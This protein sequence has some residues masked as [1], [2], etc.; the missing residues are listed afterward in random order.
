MA[1]RQGN[2]VKR[3]Y[4]LLKPEEEDALH[5]SR[6]LP[7]EQRPF[8]RL[9]KRLLSPDSLL[10]KR[11]TLKQLPSPPAEAGIDDSV[12]S[13]SSSTDEQYS[14]FREDMLL[15]FVLFDSTMVRIQLLRNS[16]EKERARYATE[17]S[18]IM[19]TSDSVRLNITQ[20]RQELEEEQ[21]KLAL[22]KQYDE[23]TEKITS[24][25]MLR[26][27]E[28]QEAQLEKLEKE[29]AELGKYLL[30]VISNS[31]YYANEDPY[32]E[33]ESRDYARTWAER[34]EQFGKIKKEAEHLQRIIR[35]E[36]EE[37]ERKEGMEGAAM[38]GED[39]ST[40]EQM[41][42]FGTPGPEPDG[43]TPMQTQGE[44]HTRTRRS[45]RNI[46]ALG[47]HTDRRI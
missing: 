35:D 33:E 45:V 41:S 40:R 25:R 10:L 42:T 29:I 4:S 36:K 43:T 32:P 30:E 3:D 14:Q 27:R 13:E 16:N 7:I 23:L 44:T 22:R 24:N 31:D 6:L 47:N 18:K 15:D 20:L 37:A 39:V 11:P 28:D 19:E 8:Q 46:Q 17:K 12:P 1:D 38:D 21:R 9:T 2:V 34:R 26:P 5:K